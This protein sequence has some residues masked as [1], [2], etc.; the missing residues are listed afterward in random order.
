MVFTILGCAGLLKHLLIAGYPWYVWSVFIILAGF[1][2]AWLYFW[3]T[4]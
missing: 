3:R 2:I 1:A 4:K